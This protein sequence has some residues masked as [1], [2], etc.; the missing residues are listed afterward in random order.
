[1]AFASD[2]FFLLLAFYTHCVYDHEDK[3]RG[4]VKEKEED[5][6]RGRKRTARPPSLAA[7]MISI[8]PISFSKYGSGIW[9]RTDMGNEH[10]IAYIHSGP[11]ESSGSSQATCWLAVGRKVRT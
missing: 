7:T 5:T 2:I 8:H 11:Q 9:D 3:K 4:K 1:V 10:E 6:R